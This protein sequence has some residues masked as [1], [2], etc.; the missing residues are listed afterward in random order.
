MLTSVQ[1]HHNDNV[2]QE[3][4]CYATARRYS[5][6]TINQ[7]HIRLKLIN[8]ALLQVGQCGDSRTLV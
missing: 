1:E 8:Q 3:S 7:E 6:P 4:R 2:R 5:G